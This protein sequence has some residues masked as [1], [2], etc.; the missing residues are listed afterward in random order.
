MKIEKTEAQWRELLSE[1]EFHVCREKGTERAFTGEYYN[2]KR[3]GLYYCVCCNKPLFSSMA[4]Y[5]SGSGWPSYF[6]AVDSAA[7]EE[8]RDTTHGMER[9]EITCSDCG[10][11]LGHVFTDGPL[12]TGLR[13]CVNSVSLHFEPDLKDGE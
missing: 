9:V 4:K 7:V 13:Y 6:Q 2:E 11:H 12:P 1:Q 3:S 5:D 8:H 10:S